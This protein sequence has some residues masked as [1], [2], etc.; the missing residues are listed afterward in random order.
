MAAGLAV[1]TAQVTGLLRELEAKL[2]P[3]N[4]VAE[5]RDAGRP[6]EAFELLQDVLLEE[7][8]YELVMLGAELA[9]EL[10]L[11]LQAIDLL[12]RARENKECPEL[13]KRQLEVLLPILADGMLE[14]AFVAQ[15]GARNGARTSAPGARSTAP[16]FEAR[17]LA[18]TASLSPKHRAPFEEAIAK[19][20]VDRGSY[21]AAAA[22]ICL[23]L[24]DDAGKYLWWRF[25]LQIPYAAAL[26]GLGGSENEGAADALL[27]NVKAGLKRVRTTM[28]PW[29]IQRHGAALTELEVSRAQ[30]RRTP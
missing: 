27:T 22:F 17:M 19:S 24:F 13:Y 14:D 23:L 5:L 15:H 26:L 12:E 1:D 8:S 30:R 25:E 6:A 11:P 21:E 29:D 3:I 7:E 2:S 9:L 28:D 4:A 16:T 18:T 10:D 20:L